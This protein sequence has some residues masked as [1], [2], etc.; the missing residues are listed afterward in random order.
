MRT[1]TGFLKKKAS[2]TQKMLDIC[3]KTVLGIGREM[4]ISKTGLGRMSCRKFGYHYN[5][6]YIGITIDGTITFDSWLKIIKIFDHRIK[7]FRGNRNERK[8]T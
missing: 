1:T 8:K 4:I 5:C 6:G 7:N 2:G 3:A